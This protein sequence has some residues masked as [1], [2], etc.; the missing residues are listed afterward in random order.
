MTFVQ[1]GCKTGLFFL[2]V[3]RQ[4]SHP[5]GMLAILVVGNRLPVEVLHPFQIL[6]IGMRMTTQN[7]VDVARLSHHRLVAIWF[8]RPSQMGKADHKVALLI[9]LQF[10]GHTVSHLHRIQEAD[11]RTGLFSTNPSNS[12]ARPKTPIFT[13]LRLMMT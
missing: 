9:F 3:K 1:L 12:G 4:P 10:T 13:P 11:T 6:Q 5:Y 2:Q 8:V 7:E